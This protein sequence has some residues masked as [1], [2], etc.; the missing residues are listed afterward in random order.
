[1][2]DIVSE[3]ED[4]LPQSIYFAFVLFLI[5]P[6]LYFIIVISVIVTHD[7]PLRM[8][9]FVLPVLFVAVDQILTVT[10]YFHK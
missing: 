7:A 8:P 5:A 6:F 10:A 4:L 1:M 2:Y 9:L 3:P